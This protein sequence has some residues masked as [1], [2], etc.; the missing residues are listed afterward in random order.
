MNRV[1]DR[2]PPAAKVGLAALS[3]AMSAA[4]RNGLVLLKLI[5]PEAPLLPIVR[6]TC[7][8]P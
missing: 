8:V 5:G 2:L 6:K 3:V 7:W 4:V 1:I